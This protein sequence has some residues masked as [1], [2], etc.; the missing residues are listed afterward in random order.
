MPR[1]RREK[2]EEKKQGIRDLRRDL[3]DA[4]NTVHYRE[5]AIV[6]ERNA[7]PIA[8]LVPIGDW[9]RALDLK[10]VPWIE[11]HY[12]G[13]PGKVDRNACMLRFQKDAD[14]YAMELTYHVP[15]VGWTRLAG[16]LEGG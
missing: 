7:K 16:Q 8:A 9:Q 15:E 1:E 10:D 11:Y 5:E 13:A 4:V 3:S 6:V 2:R 14:V 12:D